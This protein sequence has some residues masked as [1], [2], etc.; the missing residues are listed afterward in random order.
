MNDEIGP[1]ED[2][3]QVSGPP[4][5]SALRRW[6][7]HGVKLAA[8]ILLTPLVIAMIV[9]VA[10]LDRDITAPT[11]IKTRIEA[12]AADFLSG[13]SLKFGTVTVNLGSDLHPRV[14]LRDTVLTDADGTAIARIPVV[15][16]LMSPRGLILQGDALMQDV[17]L[18]GAQINLRR[19]AD[20]SVALAFQSG[21]ADVGQ[22][23]SLAE[24]LDQSDQAFEQ[25]A[26]AALETIRADGLIINY[27]DAR[28]GQAW[29]VDGG[30]INLD[31]RGDQTDLRGAF[32]VLSGGAGVTDLN[33]TYNSQR[34]SRAADFGVTITD[35]LA[36]DIAA[37]SAALSWMTDINAPI[38]LT[39]RTVLDEAGALGPLNATLEL[40]RGALQPNTATEPIRFDTAKAYLN[41]DPKTDTISFDQVEITSDWGQLRATGQAFLKDVTD[42]LPQSLVGQFG[43]TDTVFNPPGVY[44]D[45]LSLPQMQVDMRLNL[46]P[47]AIDLGQVFVQSDDVSILTTGR[48]AATDAGW[49]VA[50]DTQI[51][52]MEH[53]DLLRLWPATV[54]AKVRGW[55]VDQV[56]LATYKDF[57]LAF[58]QRPGQEAQMAGN[59]AFEGSE[60]WFLNSM[61]PIEGGA[62]LGSFTADVFST[63]LDAGTIRAPSGGAMNVAGSTLFLPDLSLDPRPAEYDLQLSGSMTAALALMDLPP[64]G[65]TSRAKLPVDVA[66]GRV[67]MSI[68]L[69]HPM[70]RGIVPSEVGVGVTAVLRDL[71]SDRL[72]PNRRLSADRLTLFADK[73]R[74]EI[75][76]P[77]TVDGVAIN[78]SWVQRFDG[79]GSRLQAGMTL[80]ERSLTAFNVALPPG[81]V[82]GSSPGRLDLR[83]APGAAPR[84]TVTSDLRGMRVAIPA[85]GWAKARQT[86]GTLSVSGRLGTDPQ[87]EAFQIQGGGLDA[88]GDVTFRADG[89]LDRARFS[90]VQVGNWL[91]APITLRGRGAGRPVGVEIRGGAIDLRRASFGPS[92]G[93]ETGPISIALDRLQVTQGIALN[94][95][96]GDFTSG[97]G[98]AGQFTARIN[99]GVD[100]Q[101][102]VA[103]RNGRSAVRLLSNDAGG[104]ARAMGLLRNAVGGTLD[105]T[106][107]PAGG[108]GT[109]DG[110]LA[111][112][113]LRIKDA[114]AIA[115]L[116]DAISVIGL[117]QQLDGQGIAFDEVDARFRLT[118]Q[119]IILTESSAVGPGL[120]ISL[121]GLYTLATQQMDFQGVI[122]PLYLINSIG[123][124]FTRRG[125]GL[126]GFNFNI[127]GTA[128]AP[129]VSVNPLSALTPGM[130]R[131]IFRRAPPQV[132]Q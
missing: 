131:E 109:F 120:G 67:Q 81:S 79:S 101:G 13:G 7:R 54:M 32:T 86:P 94:R 51:D 113:G 121:D 117:L 128:A 77:A 62:G 49:D 21:G 17:Q 53:A 124:I 34:G 6:T 100:I 83:I 29:T 31:L 123:A 130:F 10:I 111:I 90:R 129:Q 55:M 74:L 44:E 119:Q 56:P 20:G 84:Y 18:S 87:V 65:L 63:T 11:W 73:T 52:R 58:R 50:L 89:S 9:A 70:K 1:K 37:Q 104:V 33:V 106:L 127:A 91:N 28:A 110:A 19:N 97:G 12:S 114:P 112:R 76:G 47:F 23:G 36:S 30:Q 43:F 57:H 59:Y 107:L 39:M 26:L 88:R 41:F 118:P 72:I 5:R 95:F 108:D 61:P 24:L 99:D 122:S 92:G 15:R 80:S 96:A 38:S 69:T 4:P 102:T 45:G 82:A 98:F 40:G 60:V 68:T 3:E 8:V 105:L 64:L 93:G 132:S 115:A 16:G 46:K 85:V 66:D 22:A 35:A 71:S 103:P 14:T 42:G 125:E 48:F 116:L 2:D 25:P 126:I 27:Q 75:E 78:G